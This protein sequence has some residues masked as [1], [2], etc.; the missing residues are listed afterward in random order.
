MILGTSGYIRLVML[1]LS[2]YI[3]LGKVAEEWGKGVSFENVQVKN[4]ASRFL[5]QLSVFLSRV[6]G[7]CTLKPLISVIII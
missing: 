4:N 2:C 6:R 1:V 5:L 3:L 7:S